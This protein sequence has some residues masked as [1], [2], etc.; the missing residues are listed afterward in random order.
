MNPAEYC[1]SSNTQNYTNSQPKMGGYQQRLKYDLGTFGRDLEQ[2]TA[3]LERVLDPIFVHPKKMCRA[4][5]VGHLGK[6]GV[7]Y[8][9]RVPLVDTESELLNLTRPVTKDPNYKYIPQCSSAVSGNDISQDGTGTGYPG[10]C[11]M[12]ENSAEYHKRFHFPSCSFKRE[13]TRIS[14]PT[15]TMRE[16]GINRFQPTYLDHQH[17]TRWENQAEVGINDR[18]VAKDNHVPCIPVPMDQTA[19]LPVS[20]RLPLQETVPVSA[21][22]IEPLH[23]YYKACVKVR[24]TDA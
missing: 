18:M 5:E 7:S 16:I 3:P 10:G 2:S 19:A 14:N 1:Y 23:N 11:D 20:K 9:T 4:A 21:N 24:T 15:C 22:P 12:V 8:D 6:V 17:P 13:Y